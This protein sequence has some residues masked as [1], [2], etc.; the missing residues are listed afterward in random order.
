M[1]C[2]NRDKLRR[3][4]DGRYSRCLHR[5]KEEPSMAITKVWIEPGCILCSMSVAACSAVFEIIDDAESSRVKP[6]VDFTQHEAE[7]KEAAE[8]CPVE[9]IKY[10][11]A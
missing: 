3:T 4:R 5:E 9:V 7:I 10:E 2:E 1:P 6:D 8:G 11:E